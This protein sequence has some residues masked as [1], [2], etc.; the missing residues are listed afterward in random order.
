MMKAITVMDYIR[1]GGIRQIVPYSHYTKED[2]QYLV[3]ED[4]VWDSGFSTIFT[5][6][7]A[8]WAEIYVAFE[9]ATSAYFSNSLEINPTVFEEISAKTPLDCLYRYQDKENYL[10][11]ENILEELR[12]E[13]E[14]V[15]FLRNGIDLH[16][17]K[18]QENDYVLRHITADTAYREATQQLF[19]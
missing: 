7:V 11:S 4:L 14:I 16:F 10:T 19:K 17:L 18:N 6:E 13:D 9:N 2:F 12:D 5:L 8:P 3:P 15:L 1:L